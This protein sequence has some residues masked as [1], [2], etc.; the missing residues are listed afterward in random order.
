MTARD[1]NRRSCSAGIALVALALASC[2]TP[3]PQATE[4]ELQRRVEEL[5]K[6]LNDA[7]NALA[8]ATASPQRIGGTP[9]ELYEQAR[10]RESEGRFADAA[11]LY[12]L[13]ARHGNGTAARRLGEIYGM[14]MP[15]VEL[16]YGE[17]LKWLNT[18]RVLGEEPA[19]AR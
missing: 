15:G 2:A 3:Q 8:L 12:R 13:S 5:Q 4:A 14:G 17:S 9:G 11:R 1:W 10:A 16:N 19:P 6:Q 18:A 7:K